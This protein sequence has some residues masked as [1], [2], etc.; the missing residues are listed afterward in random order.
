MKKILLLT[1][2]LLA[3]AT[4]WAENYV[5]D[6]M[7]IGGNK[8]ETNSLK[9]SYANQGWTVVDQ[10]LNAGAGSSSDYIFLLYKTADE[11]DPNA[12]FITNFLI[13][14]T[15]GTA[16]DSFLNNGRIYYL[17]PFDGSDYFKGNKG[18]LNSHCGSGSA[19]IHLYYTKD[20]IDEDYSSVKSI[21]FSDTQAGGVPVAGGSTGYDFN[22]GCGSNSAYIFM[23]TDKSQGWTF[24]KNIDGSLCNITGFDGP[25]LNIRSVTVPTVLDGAQVFNFLGNVFSGFTNLESMVFDDN[26][27]VSQMPS[28]QGCT[29]FKHVRTGTVIDKTPPSMIIIPESAFAG[30]AI[31]YITLTSVSSIGNYAFSGCSSLRTVY[32]NSTLHSIGAQAFN[33]CGSMSH[34]WFDG[35][36]AQWNAVSKNSQWKDGANFL[37]HWHCTVTFDANGHGIAPD[38]QDIQWSNYDKATEPAAPSAT[39]CAFQGWYTEADC[40][41]RWNFNTVVPGDMTLYAKWDVQYAFNSTTGELALLWGEFNKDHKW[42]SDVPASAVKTV[43]STS[44]VSFTGDCSQLFKDF[45]NCTSMDLNSVNTANVNSMWQ[46]FSNCSK[47]TTLDL[48][49]WNTS[50]VTRTLMTFSSCSNLTS[51]NLAGWNIN[52]VTNLGGMFLECRNLTTIYVTTAWDNRDVTYSQNTFFNC[53]KLVGGCGTTFIGGFVDKTYARIDHGASEPGYLTGVFTLTLPGEVTASATPIFSCGDTSYYTAGNTVTLTY[54][55]EVPE[56]QVVIFSVNGSTIRGDTFPMPVDDVVVT[57]TVSDPP[58]YIFD[59]ITGELALLWGEFNRDNKWGDDVPAEAVTSV[60]ATSQVSFT[61]NCSELFFGFRNCTSME[62]DSVGTRD[63]NDMSRMFFMCKNLKSL[64]LSGWDTSNVN[65]MSRMFEDCEHTTSFNLSGWNTHNVNNMGSM[66][67]ICGNLTTI[68]LSGWDT[69]NVTNMKEMFSCCGRLTTIYVTTNWDTRNVADSDRMFN[70]CILLVGGCGTTYDADHTD[71]EYARI[72][73]GPSEPGYFT[74]LVSK[75][76][77]DINGDGTVD[78]ADMNICIN[79]ILGTNNDPAATALADL[80]GDRTV[81]ISDVNALIN[82]ILSGE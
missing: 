7:V 78:V 72:D 11:T 70:D 57:V 31:E 74:G 38:A 60:T 26:T 59:S 61:G 49:G 48:S 40:I 35:S 64:D 53:Q 20:Y 54:N 22:T 10:D 58:R 19:F 51:L 41:H 69:R 67:M 15:D 68:D 8:S 21:S 28:L 34:L 25:K 80:N 16:P 66:F 29:K 37:A 30:T 23:H 17:V 75:K 46:M 81:D 44:Q 14:T 3:A 12:T 45:S 33:G 63:V 77:G 52:A 39:C 1:V 18:D 62:L 9:T 55:G 73:R 42:G 4:V 5:T 32:A 82:I 65:D 36:D 76:T 43:T 6:V 2:A 50:N 47:L 71:K 13:S 79:I 27:A 24:S 56:G